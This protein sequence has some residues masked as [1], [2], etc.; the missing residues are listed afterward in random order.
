MEIYVVRKGGNRET[1]AEKDVDEIVKEI[2]EEAEEGKRGIL[3]EGM[4][5]E[6]AAIL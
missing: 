6:K 5:D 4:S 2:T 3:Q 1:M